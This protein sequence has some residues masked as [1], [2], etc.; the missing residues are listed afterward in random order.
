MS[1]ETPRQEYIVKVASFG[2]GAMIK[3]YKKYIGKHV[4]VRIMSDEEYEQ[5]QFMKQMS[6]PTKEPTRKQE[7][8]AA[9]AYIDAEL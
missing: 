6:R 2:N 3:S 5:E 9:K 1:R 4:K 7:Q 8:K